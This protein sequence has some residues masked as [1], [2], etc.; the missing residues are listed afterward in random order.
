MQGCTFTHYKLIQN[1]N[2]S[3]GS[4]LQFR[5]LILLTIWRQQLLGF[6]SHFQALCRWWS[7]S[8]DFFTF[9]TL[10]GG[11]SF[12]CV[13]SRQNPVTQYGRRSHAKNLEANIKRE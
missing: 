6:K 2:A 4:K 5:K 7:E 3:K 8:E 1:T 13:M 10:L 12:L 9:K 11:W